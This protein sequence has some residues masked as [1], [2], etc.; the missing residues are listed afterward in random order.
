MPADQSRRILDISRPVVAG[1]PVWPGDTPPTR[2]VLLDMG[3]FALFYAAGEF[4]SDGRP[5]SAGLEEARAF[6]EREVLPR[7]RAL[8][9][10]PAGALAPAGAVRGGDVTGV[11]R[12][13]TD[14]TSH[15]RGPR[16]DGA[17]S[18]RLRALG[19]TG[20]SVLDGGTRAWAAAGCEPSRMGIGP[21]PAVRKLMERLGLKISDFD[22]IELNEAFASQGIAV[23]RQLGGQC[24]D[25]MPRFFSV[26]E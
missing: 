5:L 20:V 10:R 4:R 12:D 13:A 14:T 8:A 11:H 9:P 21:V 3:G 16:D 7:L 1:I 22:L 25:L 19:Y 17:H 23:L 15:E 18:E 24:V 6:V 2:E 26:S